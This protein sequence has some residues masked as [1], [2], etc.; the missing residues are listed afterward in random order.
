MAFPPG[1]GCHVS[2][3]TY[4]FQHLNSFCFKKADFWNGLFI[5]IPRNWNFHLFSCG[6]WLSVYHREHIEL[7]PGSNSLQTR[8]CRQ[9]VSLSILSEVVLSLQLPIHSIHTQVYYKMA[10]HRS[11]IS[12]FCWLLD[13]SLLCIC[14]VGIWL[15]K[16]L[17]IL[18]LECFDG[19]NSVLFYVSPLLV[20]SLPGLS[21]PWLF[22]CT[23]N[24]R[25]IWMVALLPF[26]CFSYC[27][28]TTL[29]VRW[30]RETPK[31]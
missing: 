26:P 7:I 10:W 19:V 29:R 12:I 18:L 6:F 11:I 4:C 24:V 30:N 20:E 3:V 17:Y 23:L 2:L 27:I 21:L 22:V 25:M 5:H 9:C 8:I 1:N 16:V 14:G 13:W 31:R 28:L 15:I